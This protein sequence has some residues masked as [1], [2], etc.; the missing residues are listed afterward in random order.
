MFSSRESFGSLS[1]PSSLTFL[2]CLTSSFPAFILSCYT[3]L[4][5]SHFP[6]ETSANSKLPELV[7]FHLINTITRTA[8]IVIATGTVHGA[9]VLSAQQTS[10]SLQPRSRLLHD[11]LSCSTLRQAP[12]HTLI[13]LLLP[14]LY[15][16]L[17]S[18]AA[19]N[20]S[21]VQSPPSNLTIF[22]LTDIC[23]PALNPPTTHECPDSNTHDP[24]SYYLLAGLGTALLLLI[25]SNR[26]IKREILMRRAK[27]CVDFIQVVAL[28][29]G[30]TV[31]E[32]W[33]GCMW[34][35]CEGK[36][37]ARMC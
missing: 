5:A 10:T 36:G 16:P 29:L 1:L 11:R 12:H 19:Q 32:R 22:H 26:Y 18:R 6:I 7:R 9:A 17:H 35:R 27:M 24:S 3:F 13:M 25:I 34:C 37:R 31:Y 8:I 20:G 14:S 21:A 2:V 23:Q 4:P 28:I 30:A 33:G 15:L